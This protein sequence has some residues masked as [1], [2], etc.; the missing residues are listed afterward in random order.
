MSNPLPPSPH[1]PVAEQRDAS[2]HTRQLTGLTTLL[3]LEKEARH[4]P[5]VEALGFVMVN[6]TVR[7]FRYNQAAFWEAAEGKIRLLSLSGVARFDPHAP[8]VVWLEQF[9]ARQSRK[10]TPLPCQPL[11]L[12]Q[13]EPEMR[14]AWQ[15][16]SHPHVLWVP[17]RHPA[18][19]DPLGGLWLARDQPWENGEQRLV[20]HLADGYGHALALLSRP[21]CWQRLARRLPR[22]LGRGLRL[23][24]LILLLVLL[25]SIPVRQSVL[26]PATVVARQPTVIA[27]PVDGVVHRFHVLPN[28][29]VVVDQP[30]FDLDPTEVNNRFQLATEELAIARAHYQKAA[31]KAFQSAESGGELAALRAT[32]ARAASQAEHAETLLQRLQVRAPTAGVA[33]FADVNQWLGR[34]VRVGERILSLADPNDVEVDIVLP[35]ADALVLQPGAET[36]LFLNT[37][38]LHPLSGVLRYASYEASQTAEGILAYRLRSRF[39]EAGDQPR[40][41]LG[42][43]GT[44]K[45]FGER[46]P[47]AFY[48]LRRPLAALRQ[49]VG[50]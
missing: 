2:L 10:A 20:E 35:V 3:T 33:V 25:L 11:S 8:Q 43:K 16:W 14:T 48:L 15:E 45:L 26:A 50:W 49:K 13:V 29:E 36:Q 28:Q 5:D 30:L 17:L 18:G 31:N 38:P 40:P 22:L 44:A 19:G 24:L 47:L 7:L 39:Q 32:M 6:E 9:I 37:D 27:A 21:L 1:H 4:A 42:L 34:P 41:R 12:E 23:A 46:V